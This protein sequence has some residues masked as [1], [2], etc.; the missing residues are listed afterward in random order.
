MLDQRI[1]EVF[2]QTFPDVKRIV[3]PVQQM[4]VKV[5]EAKTSAIS[6]PGTNVDKRVLGLLEDI[7]QRVPKQLDVQVSQMVID[8]ETVRISGKT[9]TFNTVDNM[10]S[11]LESSEYFSAVAINTANLDRTGKQ[12]QFEIKLQRKK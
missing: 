9:D 8:Q 1:T 7:S 6:A 12:V 10:K 4:K 2:K 3:D 11:G 5:N